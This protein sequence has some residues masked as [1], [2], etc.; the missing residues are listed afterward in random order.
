MSH[1]HVDPQ[2]G[3]RTNSAKSGLQALKPG[4]MDRPMQALHSHTGRRLST[5]GTSPPSGTARMVAAVSGAATTSAAASQT[6]VPQDQQR[7]QRGRADDVSAAAALAASQ[8]RERRKRSVLHH[9]LRV[10]SSVGSCF[11]AAEFIDS[12]VRLHG[13]CCDNLRAASLA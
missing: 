1:H 10:F 7:H 2:V 8:E 13:W 12:L 11:L 9:H 5:S 4:A 3:R 6:T